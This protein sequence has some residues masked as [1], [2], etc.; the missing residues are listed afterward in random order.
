MVTAVRLTRCWICGDTCRLEDCKID[1]H[2][3]PV[4]EV[5][6]VASVALKKATSVVTQTDHARRTG[7]R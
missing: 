7:T 5:C 2:G 1:E 4:H 3:L 6:Y